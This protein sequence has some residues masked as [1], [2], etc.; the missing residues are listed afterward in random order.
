VIGLWHAVVHNEYPQPAIAVA[1]RTEV[2]RASAE[3]LKRE[4]PAM[5]FDKAHLVPRLVGLESHPGIGSSRRAVVILSD[6]RD[7]DNPRTGPGSVRT[8]DNVLRLLQD[9]DVTFFPVGV[10]PK[11]GA[12]RLKRPATYSG[13]ETYSLQE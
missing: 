5:A 11:I 10:G 12:D 8:W 7:E 2:R 6:S 3:G 13:G 1:S 4:S 9:Q